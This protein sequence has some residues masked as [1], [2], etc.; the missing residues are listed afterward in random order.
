VFSYFHSHTDAVVKYVL[1][2][3][4]HHQRK[5]F[6]QEYLSLLEKFEVSFEER[7]LFDFIE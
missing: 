4:A 1:N 6:K 2:Q 5:T 3:E 7:Y